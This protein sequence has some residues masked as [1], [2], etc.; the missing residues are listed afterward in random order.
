MFGRPSG[1]DFSRNFWRKLQFFKLSRSYDCLFF[2]GVCQKVLEKLTFWPNLKQNYFAI[3][4]AIRVFLFC[5]NP[6]SMDTLPFKLMR[7]II[8]FKGDMS[9]ATANYL[10][11]H[12]F[13]GGSRSTRIQT[14]KSSTN[15]I[16]DFDELEKLKKYTWKKNHKNIWKS[17]NTFKKI[18]AHHS[19]LET[20]IYFVTFGPP[21]WAVSG[22]L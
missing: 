15:E 16:I 8:L 17:S 22:R 12:G 11:R 3:R 19:L 7:L 10:Y 6:V 2:P 21:L 20:K 13:E 1:Q 4:G 14:R 9:I 18:F 5:L